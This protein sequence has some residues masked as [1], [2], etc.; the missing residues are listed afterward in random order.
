MWR[1][2]GDFWD[3]WPQLKDQFE[4]C[5]RWAPY[6]SPGAWPDEDMLPLGRIGIRAERGEPRMTGFTRDE[7]YTLM[8]LFAIVRSPL[9]FGGDLPSND[10][11]T[12]SLITNKNVLEVNRHS[13]NNKQL[14]KENDLIA[15]IADDPET[16]DKYLALFNVSDQEPIVE[17]KA[18]WKS[19]LIN[20][21]TPGQS[22][23]IDIDITGAEKLFLVVTN[24]EDRSF[25]RIICD[26]I[27][28]ALTGVSGSVNLTDLKWT[29]ASSGRREPAINRTI[30]GDKLNID[31]REY[32]HGI[33]TT[34]TSIIE[35]DLPKGY[36]RFAG[37]AGIDRSSL[38]QASQMGSGRVSAEFLVF[39]EDPAGPVPPDFTEISV[40]FDQIGLSGTHSVKDLW[41][42][43]NLGKF[44]DTFTQ[45]VNR[46][47]AGLYKIH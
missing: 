23:D 2:V 20:Q 39:V 19:G 47:G 4:I 8:S 17:S 26:W 36:T 32:E 18:I 5:E 38:I 34:G 31:D 40:R 16:D 33:S 13:V 27:E 37:K 45:T 1:T 41:T 22:I 42:G 46:H 6:V 10:D 28:P 21:N 11:F 44:T 15:W 12:L 25:G 43:E 9:M 35:Y 3:N 30:R 24:E 14:F 7:Q 29:K